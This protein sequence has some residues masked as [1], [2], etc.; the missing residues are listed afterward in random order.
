VTGLLEALAPVIALVMRVLL[1]LFVER[2]RP[3][4]EDAR[5]QP[6]LRERLRAKVRE[7]WSK[8]P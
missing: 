2:S 3:T 1:D 4:A 6:E 8:K 7:K 5:Q